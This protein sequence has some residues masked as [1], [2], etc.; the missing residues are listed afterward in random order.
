[1]IDLEQWVLSRLVSCVCVCVCVCVHKCHS[2]CT[3]YCNGQL[4]NVSCVNGLCS[5][6]S[7]KTQLGIHVA[8]RQHISCFLS[9]FF[10]FFFFFSLSVYLSVCLS[11][12]LLVP[13]LFLSL[14]FPFLSYFY[15]LFPSFSVFLDSIYFSCSFLFFP[16]LFP[17]LS[18]FIS[19]LF[20]QSQH[21]FYSSKV[22]NKVIK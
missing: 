9:S 5:Y 3:C 10:S 1:M 21:R 15:L 16:F 14:S 18:N 19:V 6:Y 7:H 13:F 12:S 11:L 20:T 8:T 2:N 17:S 22:Y 4:E